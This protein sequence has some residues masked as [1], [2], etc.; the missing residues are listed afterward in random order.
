M[1]FAH[2]G[3]ATKF[4]S[5]RDTIIQL[6]STNKFPRITAKLK[7]SK[8][9]SNGKNDTIPKVI[10]GDTIKKDTSKKTNAP[11]RINFTSDTSKR[12]ILLDTLNRRSGPDTSKNGE[13]DI[14][15]VA[16]S[17]FNNI[18]TGVSYRIGNA[19]VTYGDFELD[20]EYIR[21]DRKNH[22]IYA[23][24]LKDK[25]TGRYIGRPISKQGKDSPITSDSLLFNYETKR[26]LIFNP[27]TQQDGNYI[28]H[29]EAKKL[30]EDEVAYHNIIFSA[31]D[32]PSRGETPD[33]GIVITKGI[34]EKNRIISGPAYL[35]IEGVPL[36][37][38]IPFGFFPKPNT[39][40]SGIMLPTFGEDATLGFFLRDFGYYIG[41]SDYAD[42]TNLG[43]Y[44]SNGSYEVSS[45]LN[46]MN[47]YKYNG[48]LT[49]AYSSH[50][51]G[52]AGDPPH[53]DFHINWQHAQN[54]NASPGSTF[55]ASVNAGTSSFYQNNPASTGYN[56]QQL[57]QNNL[58]SS[59]SYSRT[60]AGTPFN[61]TTS[62]D[63]SQDLTN[64]TV[65]LT[66]P[67]VN[68]SMASINPFD[69]K[70]QVSEKKWYQK[71]TLAYNMRATNTLTN[72]PESELFKSETLT[73]RMQNGIEHQIPLGLSLNIFN[74]FQ[75]NISV[76]YDERWYFQSINK[77]YARADSLATDTIPGFK[78]AGQY[79][80]NTGLSTKLYGTL[81]FKKGKLEAIRHV[82]TPNISFGYSPDYS[83][84]DRPYNRI[85]VSNATVPYPVIYQRYSIFSNSSIGYPQGG[86]QA[87][88]NFSVDN[89]VEAKFRAKSTDTSQTAKKVQLLQSLSF[90]TFYNFAADSFK[91]TPISV[92]G[93]TGLFGDKV[94]VTFGGTFDPYVT[95]VY[96]T[97]ANGRVF[98]YPRKF[99]RYTWL[100][101]KIPKLTNFNFSISGTLNPAAF[102]PSANNNNNV[103]P[104]AYNPNMPNT[105]A[106]VT[107]AQ[108]QSLALLNSD[109]SAYVD[110][111]IPWNLVMNYNFSYGDN[112]V[113]SSHVN[114]IMLSGD[115]SLTPK[116]KVQF[117]TNYDL[118]ARQLSSATS[119]AIYRDLHCWDLSIN[120]LPFGFYKSYNITLKV[121]S[122]ILQAL[123]LSKRSDYTS[124]ANFNSY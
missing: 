33:Y 98:A 6:D 25:R 5:I 63:H 70:D 97:I 116:W 109:P 121:K 12:G 122:D 2:T 44:Y 80:F 115:F 4:K 30:N 91:L 13:P 1:A 88:L 45:S 53:K 55:S 8:R 27:F 32:K 117:N 23:S 90:S 58:R 49:L 77:H 9:T 52:L 93:H 89:N 38:G 101:G 102:H 42:L 69:S 107:E 71:I 73:K 84:L 100:D 41:L 59:I 46:Y 105:M 26:G 123:K 110:F 96:D 24:G 113:S 15:E 114:T 94:N 66:L 92:S 7:K 106:N 21:I 60:W 14:K 65:S 20:A 82:I 17:S 62:I 40:A 48:N 11:G 61:L 34:G 95:K 120:W 10:A 28:S 111:N 19:R 74:Y 79:N 39:R 56:L 104:G 68:F 119:F 85:I 54:P 35:E 87:G 31:C 37:I 124:N 18:K 50:N 3:K 81:N 78:R 64:K 51:Y 16:D 118:Q 83:S 43:T 67:N 22:L 103:M 76:N 36:P 72:V 47:R 108:R 86:T 112:Y 75:F 57:T 29:G 99:N